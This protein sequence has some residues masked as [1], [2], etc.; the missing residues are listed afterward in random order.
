MGIMERVSVVFPL[1]PLPAG[2]KPLRVTRRPMEEGDIDRVVAFTIPTLTEP[3][4]NLRNFFA[5]AAADPG[6][7]NI[8]AIANGEIVGH[9]LMRTEA[10]KIWGHDPESAPPE[11]YLSV[12]AVRP[13]ERGR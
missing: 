2:G 1:A 4:H 9:G 11:S 6:G 8:V 5:D 10:H 7:R 12:M 3:P 13:W